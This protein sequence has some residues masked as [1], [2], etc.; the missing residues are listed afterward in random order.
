MLASLVPQIQWIH[1]FVTDD[2]LSCV[3]LAPD[4]TLVREHA[5]RA[6]LPASRIAAVRQLINPTTAGLARHRSGLGVHPVRDRLFN[7]IVHPSTT[8]GIAPP[9]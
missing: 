1:S 8:P 9:G 6:G 5:R 4:E 2:K 3:Y 7:L